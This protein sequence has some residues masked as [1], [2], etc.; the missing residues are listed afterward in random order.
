[1]TTLGGISMGLFFSAVVNSTEKA[2][3]I[4]PLILIPQLLLSGFLTPVEDTYVN[5]ATD[6]P[7]SAAAYDLYD[8]RG[9]PKTMEPIEKRDGLGPGRLLT[10]A[11]LARWSLDALLHVASM[12]NVKT[13]D[14]L[15]EGVFVPAYAT[16]LNGESSWA[17]DVSYR[18]H[19]WGDIALIFAF[20]MGLL[21]LTMWSLKRHDVL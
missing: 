16:V 17:I 2:V 1:L 9:K 15:A 14:R 3:S 8:Q 6:K 7:A 21:P 10:T 18:L 4:L 5:L 19:T 12:D 13:R 20:S 11:V